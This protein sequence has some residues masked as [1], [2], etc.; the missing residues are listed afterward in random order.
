M[1]DCS[2]VNVGDV[3]VIEEEAGNTGGV[4]RWRG[5]S[6]MGAGTDS[7]A[8]QARRAR[9]LKVSTTVTYLVMR[10]LGND[11]AGHWWGEGRCTCN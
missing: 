8:R 1:D 6:K 2:V 10:S 3:F 4:G 5:V 7:W 11:V 9:V